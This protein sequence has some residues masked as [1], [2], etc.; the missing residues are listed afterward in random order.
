M[1]PIRLAVVLLSFVVVLVAG[2]AC[3]TKRDCGLCMCSGVPQC[4]NGECD[5]SLCD[6]FMTSQ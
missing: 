6:R 1:I 3:T 5:F 2:Q 4:I